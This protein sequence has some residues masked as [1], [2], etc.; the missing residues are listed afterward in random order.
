MVF[1]NILAAILEFKK[2]KHQH[3]GC[4]ECVFCFITM[5]LPEI[6]VWKSNL[7]NLVRK[8]EYVEVINDFYAKVPDAGNGTGWFDQLDVFIETEVKEDE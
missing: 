5:K 3:R 6:V 7:S 1:S 8:G 2:N 4:V